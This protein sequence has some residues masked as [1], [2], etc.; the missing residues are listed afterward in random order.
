[1][2]E[3]N[4]TLVVQLNELVALPSTSLVPTAETV[5]AASAAA[6]KSDGS[7]GILIDGAFVNDTAPTLADA[8]ARISLCVA[9]LGKQGGMVYTSSSE[10]KRSEIVSTS[11]STAKID[12]VGVEFDV[13]AG[14]LHKDAILGSGSLKAV[15]HNEKLSAIAS[16]AYNQYTYDKVNPF[17]NADTGENFDSYTITIR[18]KVGARD[19]TEVIRVYIDLLSEYTKSALETILGLG[20]LADVTAP[21]IIVPTWTVPAFALNAA[22]VTAGAAGKIAISLVTGEVGGTYT[23]T[24]TDD[25][26]GT[27]FT[28]TASIPASGTS[29][30]NISAGVISTT[31]DWTLLAVGDILTLAVTITDPFGNDVA[32]T[33]ITHTLI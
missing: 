19:I 6:S 9:H 20:S 7:L 26:A 14:T 4:T 17:T 15:R 33:P 24:I 27:D 16:G 28:K 8:N 1:M 23:L 3:L 10:F 25:G 32:C 22:Q 12:V 13:S 29:T 31:Y 5:L 11:Y 21:T 18:K 30:A 2:S